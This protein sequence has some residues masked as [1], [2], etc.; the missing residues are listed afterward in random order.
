VS[1]IVPGVVSAGGVSSKD[2]AAKRARGDGCV[3]KDYYLFNIYIYIYLSYIYHIYIYYVVYSNINNVYIFVN[4]KQY[5][6]TNH[7]KCY[8]CAHYQTICCTTVLIIL[9]MTKNATYSMYLL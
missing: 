9:K 3:R 1:N 6:T 5:T 8:Y 2:T 7:L 4:N